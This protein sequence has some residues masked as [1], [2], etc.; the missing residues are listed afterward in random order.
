MVTEV[1]NT[2]VK[3]NLDPTLPKVVIIAVL[4]F[5]EGI[6]IPSYTVI[7]QSRWPTTLEFTGFVLSA[8]IQLITFLL[9]FLETGQAPVPPAKTPPA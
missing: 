2:M 6:A 9:V 5:A 4:L 8:F 1:I 3:L 7:T